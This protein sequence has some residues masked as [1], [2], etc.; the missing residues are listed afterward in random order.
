MGFRNFLKKDVLQDEANQSRMYDYW[1]GGYHNFEI[2]RRRCHQL[3]HVFPELPKLIRSYR[4]FLER[5]VEYIIGEGITQILDIGS[6]LTNGYGLYQIVNSINP[7]VRV[8]YVDSDPITVAHCRYSF[9]EKVNAK[10]FSANISN[11]YQILN[12][13]GLVNFFDFRQPVA[14]VMLSY[15]ERIASDEKAFRIIRIF[16]QIIANHSMMVLTHISI[17]ELDKWTKQKCLKYQDQ[18]LVPLYFRSQSKIRSFLKDFS[19]VPPGYVCLPA[20]RYD[21]FEPLPLNLEKTCPILV[22]VGKKE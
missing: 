7:E 18:A 5:V 10:A 17:D 13:A 8:V 22:G 19:I 15:L 12:N 11:P 21:G 1:L 3:E 6:G 20:W 4:E 16:R 2:D 14:V 9:R